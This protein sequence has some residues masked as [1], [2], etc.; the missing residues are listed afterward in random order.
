MKQHALFREAGQADPRTVAHLQR[1]GH[2]EFGLDRRPVNVDDAEG[3]GRI[4]DLWQNGA[5]IEGWARYWSQIYGYL[6]DRLEAN[7]RLREATL[8]VRFEDLCGEPHAIL[9]SVLDHCRLPATDGFVD[10]QAGGIRFPSY[11]RPGFTS[12]ELALIERCT[13]ATAARFGYGDRPGLS[14]A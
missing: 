13:A 8:L 1:V 12:D 9:R 14:A 4:L 7:P 10:E 6:A 5:E 3:V 11:Y 2:F